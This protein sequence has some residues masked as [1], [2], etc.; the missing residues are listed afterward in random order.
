MPFAKFDR[1]KI[2]LLPLNERKHDLDLS[3]IIDADNIK[4]FSDPKIDK[5]AEDI[6]RAREKN[7]AVIL[8][9]GA[10]VIRAGCAKIMIKLMEDGY[11]THFATNGVY[12]VRAWVAS[13]VTINS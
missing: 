10:H 8:M 3:V 11:I 1:N 13:T 9:Y 5:L 2:K 7:A 6:I 4:P 12:T